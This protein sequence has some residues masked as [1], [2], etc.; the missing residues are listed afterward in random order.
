MFAE[1]PLR[2]AFAIFAAAAEGRTALVASLLTSL[3]LLAAWMIAPD[4]AV[5][6]GAIAARPLGASSL[7][8]VPRKARTI[9]GR[10]IVPPVAAWL[11]F[12][13]AFATRP[14]VAIEVAARRT[15]AVLAK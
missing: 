7:I 12:E 13:T 10:A 14:V 15:V 9:A 3:E 6:L 4:V 1:F 5:A 11:A 2:L 8:A